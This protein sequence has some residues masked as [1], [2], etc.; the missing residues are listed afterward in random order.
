MNSLL[1]LSVTALIFFIL[2][3]FTINAQDA[4][5]KCTKCEEQECLENYSLF[6]EFYKQDNYDEALPYWR[7]VFIE[8]P[9][10]RK[11]TYFAGEKIFTKK[12]KETEDAALIDKYIDTLFMVYDQRAKCWG[13][14]GKLI[15]KKVQYMSKYRKEG[16]EEEI[17]NM[18][19]ES[20]EL[21]GND[22]GYYLLTPY[23]TNII[24]KY[25]AKEEGYEA[26]KVES[27]YNE[28]KGIAEHNI[29][30]EDS[31]YKDKYQDVLDKMTPIYEKVMLKTELEG[32]VDCASAKEY[33]QAEVAA[34][35]D[36]LKTLQRAYESLKKFDCKSDP[37]FLEVLQKLNTIDPSANRMLFLAKYYGDQGDVSKATQ[38]MNEALALS[39]DPSDKADIYWGLAKI[40]RYKNKDY[41][42]ARDYA[43]KAAEQRPG[44]GDPYIFIGEMYVAS[45][46]SCKS[47]NEFY[48][49]AVSWVAVDQFAKAKNIDPSVTDKAN[50]LIGKYA[51]Y[52][53]GRE[54]M[55]TRDIKEGQS[56]TVKCWIGATTTAR[57]KK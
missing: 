56:Y 25:L 36:D 30:L 21:S 16:N 50:K 17:F 43:R 49:W 12:I 7:K 47:Q 55:F 18:R 39:T 15:G 1:K 3:S 52:Y 35:P 19:K 41:P 24:D 23:F 34:K 11:T 6:Y 28:L 5:E 32:I 31:K 14:R 48:G 2:G 22:A 13:E 38:M 53:P 44:W 4:K 57:A 27:I 46:A 8:N 54:D 26:D 40:H 33:Y 20:I 10:L 9:G 42:T 45:G 37:F 51:A 29:G